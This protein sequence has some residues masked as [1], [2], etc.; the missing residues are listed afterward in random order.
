MSINVNL[1]NTLLSSDLQDLPG[2]YVCLHSLPILAHKYAFLR[3][4]RHTPRD[5]VSLGVS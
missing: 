3:M 4:T 1:K 2:F 5:L